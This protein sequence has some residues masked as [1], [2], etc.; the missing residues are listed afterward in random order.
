MCQVSIAQWRNPA[1][2]ATFN[3]EWQACA[4]PSQLLCNC[5]AFLLADETYAILHFAELCLVGF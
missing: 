2:I 4:T 1:G 5:C 3:Y